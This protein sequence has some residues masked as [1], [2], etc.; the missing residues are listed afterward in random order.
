MYIYIIYKGKKEKIIIERLKVFYLLSHIILYSKNLTLLLTLLLKGILIV[1]VLLMK[2]KNS[3]HLYLSF[4][5]WSALKLRSYLIKAK[6]YPFQKTGSCNC[7]RKRCQVC[8]NVIER[9][10]V[11]STSSG[12]T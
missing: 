1:C 12:K 5:F 3:F 7:R 4:F 11:T 9:D 10:C 8:Q 2:L 6:I